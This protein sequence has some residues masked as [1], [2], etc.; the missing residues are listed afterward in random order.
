MIAKVL[1]AAKNNELSFIQNQ[2]QIQT[3][4]YWGDPQ[5]IVAFTTLRQV[6]KR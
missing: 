4:V 6:I 3:Y 1:A 2:I 5:M